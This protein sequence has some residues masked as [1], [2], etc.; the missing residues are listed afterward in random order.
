[1][2]IYAQTTNGLLGN[3]THVPPFKQVVV[4]HVGF[5]CGPPIKVSH[6]LPV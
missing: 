5:C 1:M 6:R 4:A 2:I 3:G